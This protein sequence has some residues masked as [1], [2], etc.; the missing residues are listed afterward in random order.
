MS[1]A[2]VTGFM[3]ALT[4]YSL[5][6]SNSMVITQKEIAKIWLRQNTLFV[7]DDSDGFLEPLLDSR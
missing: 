5:L 6:E 1:G 4:K 2:E 3:Q 7:S